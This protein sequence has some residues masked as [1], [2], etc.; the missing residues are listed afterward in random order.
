MAAT[1][2]S[3]KIE[4]LPLSEDS[5]YQ[6][7]LRVY[8][9]VMNWKF[10]EEGDCNPTDCG[11]IPCN[12]QYCPVLTGEP[13]APADI[14]KV[15]RCKCKIISKSPCSTNCS[16]KKNGM[17]CVAACGNCQGDGCENESSIVNF[18]EINIIEN[19]D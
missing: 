15:F 11:W 5:A 2:T 12:G 13:V 8:L 14:L 10:L 7:S 3:I 19:E 4:S 16:C 17:H 1:N 18:A 9:Q 6:H